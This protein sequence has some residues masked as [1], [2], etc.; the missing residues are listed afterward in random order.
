LLCALST[1]GTIDTQAKGIATNNTLI[2]AALKQVGYSTMAVGKW[3]VGCYVKE[4]TP[5]YRGFDNHVGFLCC[6]QID[7][8][9]K[10]QDSYI[11]MYVPYPYL[12]P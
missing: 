4:M 1:H 9:A 11:D 12:E 5:T 7:F 8:L 10:T 3:H 6:G 2:A